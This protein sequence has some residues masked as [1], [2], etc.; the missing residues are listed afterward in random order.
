[1][2]PSS[3]DATATVPT[4]KSFELPIMAYTSGG[5]KLESAKFCKKNSFIFSL[6]GMC[7]Q[8]GNKQISITNEFTNQVSI[9]DL[10]LKLLV[11]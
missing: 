2:E 4:A 3:S 6:W 5:I 9:Q 10:N 1:M 7:E 11:V 8:K